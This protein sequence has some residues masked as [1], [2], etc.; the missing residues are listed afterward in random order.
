M[1]RNDFY[2]NTQ[3]FHATEAEKIKERLKSLSEITRY[4]NKFCDAKIYYD[5]G[6]KD[7][8]GT[9]IF[10][11]NKD[12]KKIF[13]IFLSNNKG[14]GKISGHD[15][16]SE[17]F[18]DTDF[19]IVLNSSVEDENFLR[20][21]ISPSLGKNWESDEINIRVDDDE[22][23]LSNIYDAKSTLNFLR[24]NWAK[25]V[26]SD[27]IV[28]G[29]T[30][31][32]LGENKYDAKSIVFHDDFCNDMLVIPPNIRDKVNDIFTLVIFGE[33]DFEDYD[34]HS[35]SETVKKNPKLRKER[36]VKFDGKIENIL[37]HIKINQ[38]YS[39]YISVN[40]N[41]IHV[42]KITKH[43]TTKNY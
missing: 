41:Q 13:L 35:E 3:T 19:S 27:K 40:N 30:I 15:I 22:I 31:S 4:I 34:Y 23:N 20:C 16:I 2:C 11:E 42:G 9:S 28:Y 25:K 21:F 39:V 5:E 17:D 37:M 43:L 14:V 29:E 10:I 33:K 32:H 7:L 26:L 12:I 8:L 36:D 6:I 1:I 18:P 38:Q 24:N